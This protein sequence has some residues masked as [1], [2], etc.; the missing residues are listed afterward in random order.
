MVYL[1]IAG[2]GQQVSLWVPRYGEC[3][4]LSGNLVNLFT[5]VDVGLY[6]KEE[7][8]WGG[9]ERGGGGRGL[10]H[11]IIICMESLFYYVNEEIF[12]G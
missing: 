4:G 5:C 1:I 8:G 9:G 7:N 12:T 2:I 10:G 11:Y 6:D 3:W